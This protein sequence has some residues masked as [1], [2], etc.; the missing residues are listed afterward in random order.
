MRLEDLVFS[1]NLQEIMNRVLA[2]E[3]MSQAQPVEVCTKS[4]VRRIEAQVKAGEP[5]RRSRSA[6]RDHRSGCGSLAPA[7]TGRQSL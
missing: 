7:R 5:A 6:A 3:R 1:D 4:E 2:A